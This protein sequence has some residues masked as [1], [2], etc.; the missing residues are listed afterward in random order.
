VSPI[1]RPAGYFVHHQGRGHAER[2]TAIA[3]LLADRRPVVLF[4]AR[5][6]I[7]DDLDP[8]VETIRIPSLFEPAGDEPPRLAAQATPDTLH[9]A[10]LGWAGITEAVATV[11]GWFRDARP[12]LF[13]TDVSAELAQLARI[14]SVPHVAVLQHGDRRD[15][16]HMAAYDGAV[17]LL[18]PYAE[19]LEQPDRPDYLRARTCYAGGVG[20]RRKPPLDKN[21]ARRDLGLPE[22]RDIV[23]VLGG[24]GGT[25]VPTAPLTIGARAEPDTH[26]HVLGKTMSEWHETPPGNLFLHG[27]VEDTDLWLAA[28]DRVV[29]TAGNTTV[30]QVAGSGL[31]W[32]VVP[33]WRY[34]AEQVDKAEA[35]QR[36]GACACLMHWPSHARAWG[37]AWQEARSFHAEAR[38]ALLDPDAAERAACWLDDLAETLW[39]GA[40]SGKPLQA[41]AAA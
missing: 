10:P 33:E 16:G 32:I 41:G 9:C 29:T 6:D 36:L 4:C 22:G 5:D 11:T 30:H 34:F 13:V 12:A 21:A 19:S 17:G 8:R 23:L 7:F 39:A 2:A 31:P 1:A 28:A 18:A 37:K 24:G 3:N 26:W 27:W 25:G 38:A 15:P 40:P 14:A 35:L 20:I